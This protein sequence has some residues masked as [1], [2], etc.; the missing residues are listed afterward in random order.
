MVGEETKCQ[1]KDVSNPVPGQC[2]IIVTHMSVALIN[3]TIHVQQQCLI[4]YRVTDE[5]NTDETLF[6]LTLALKNWNNS[7]TIETLYG[8]KLIIE[9]T[10]TARLRLTVKW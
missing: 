7:Q 2:F 1:Q 3:K 4:N 6:F 10:E 8:R 9:I 5:R